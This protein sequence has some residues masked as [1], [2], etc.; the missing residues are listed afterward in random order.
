ARCGGLARAAGGGWRIDRAGGPVLPEARRLCEVFG[1]DP[2]GTIASGSLLMTVAP[3][4]AEAVT[5]ACRVAGIDC[6][7]IG[8]VTPASEGVALVSGRHPPPLPAL[9]PAQM[10]R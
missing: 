1:L 7:A 8:R 5:G 4:D 2:L 6:A 10:P 9:P 3:G